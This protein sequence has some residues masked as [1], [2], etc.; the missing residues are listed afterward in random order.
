MRKFFLFVFI[1]LLVLGNAVCKPFEPKS[2]YSEDED[3]IVY[4]TGTKSCRDY[5]K[6]RN[7]TDTLVLLTVKAEYYMQID[8]VREI[9]IEPY[10]SVQLDSV[11]TEQFDRFNK[12]YFISDKKISSYK[13]TI[14]MND[15]IFE[16][17]AVTSK[18]EVAKNI[19]GIFSIEN[20]N[21]IGESVIES[22]HIVNNT[23]KTPNMLIFGKKSDG[24]SENIV[25]D[26][27]TVSST[28]FELRNNFDKYTTVFVT[29]TN[30]KMTD[31]YVR[32]YQGVFYV[33]I[34][35]YDTSVL[36]E[37]VSNTQ[38]KIE[39]EIK[40]NRKNMLS[41]LKIHGIVAKNYMKI[42]FLQ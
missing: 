30:G 13:A 5:I 21:S 34:N 11:Y 16:I 41:F 2:K 28:E 7:N 25:V 15:L 35:G 9:G 17:N 37:L 38:T 24:K 26:S 22:L 6:I 1:G 14:K 10:A 32:K 20:R 36:P 29:T 4:N 27:R 33:I 19:D 39:Q 12:F 40:Q 3:L 31:A 23:Y 42:I 18:K 8:V